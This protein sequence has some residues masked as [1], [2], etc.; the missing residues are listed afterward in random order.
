MATLAEYINVT[1]SSPI[2]S[3]DCDNNYIVS[4]NFINQSAS[5]YTV[6][7]INP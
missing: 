7:P 3:Y 1:F 6:D 5:P 2:Q 4:Q